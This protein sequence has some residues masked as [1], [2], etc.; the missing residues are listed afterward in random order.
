VDESALDI[1]WAGA[2]AR[3]ATIVYVYSYNVWDSATYAVDH[4]VAPVL[5][6]TYGE[7]EMLDLVDLPGYRQLVQQANAEGITWL[8]AAGDQGATDCD[9]GNTVAEGGLAVDAPSSIPEVTS[10]GGTSL[11]DAGLY[12]NTGNTSTDASAKAYVPET[13]WNDTAAAGQIAATGGG[14]SVYFPQPSWQTSAGVP[15]D[16]WRHVPDIALNAS[17]YEVPY[18]EYCAACTDTQNGVE[19]VGGTSAATP[20]MAGVVALLNQYLKTNGLGNIN[21]TIYNLFKTAPGV[22]HN[23]ITGNNIEPC[24]YGS[25]G[26]NNGQEG[27]T[28][29]GSGYSSVV[30]F[31]SIDVTNFI[32]QW[33]SAE[34]TG[35]VVVAS[36]DQNPVYQGNAETCG[37][38]N[39]WNFLLT[40]S[41][42]AGFATSVTGF[43]I[44]DGTNSTDYSSQIA[45]ILGTSALGARQS[46]GY[47]LASGGQFGC[48][49]LA[50]VNA[51]ATETFTFSGPGWRTAL[52][53]PFQGPQTQLSI[54]GASNAASGQQ[55]YAPG[56]I[57]SVYGAALGTLSQAAATIPLPEYMAGFEATICPGNCQTATTGY[58]VPLYYVGPNQVNIQ[59][60]YEVS[61]AVDLNVGNPYQST[62]Y[63]FTVTPTA[64]GIFTLEDGSGNVNPAQTLSPGQVGTVY[65]TGVGAVSPAVPDGSAP[66]PAQVPKPRQAVTVTVGGVTAQT[67]YDAIPS[68][69]VGVLQ[70]NFTIPSNAPTGRQ[71]VV[72]SVGT[73]HSP[74]AYITIQ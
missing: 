66:T 38:A 51:P 27:F 14:A 42:E 64:P 8:A 33:S 20:T 59:I 1:E 4:V 18:Y 25:P 69:S 60:P 29:S 49:S 72:V 23:N 11:S 35:P 53:I 41:E 70:I 28:A 12:W 43:S 2:V 13:A 73:V 22:F 44:S 9:G 32:K 48:M 62:D 36:L 7:C 15:S 3:D 52:A 74:P 47:V 19:Y 61:G 68:W 34:P 26:C 31:G 54:G 6:M 45:S 65:V 71:P 58:A 24:A 56:M 5:S 46:I 21:P 30:G 63:F 17:V 55:A 57:M 40:L 39:T 50:S 37:N 16:G 10:M 67:S